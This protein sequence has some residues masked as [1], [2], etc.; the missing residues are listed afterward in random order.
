MLRRFIA[1]LVIGLVLLALFHTSF[2]ERN[3]AVVSLRDAVL[4]WQMAKLSGSV[5]F[6][7]FAFIDADEETQAAWG[8]N[9]VTPRAPVAQL[10]AF[11]LKGNPAVILID[12]DLTWPSPNG[13]AGDAQLANVL[14]AHRASCAQRCTPVLL[15]RAVAPAQRFAYAA[16]PSRMALTAIPSF[17]DKTLRT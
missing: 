8:F 3:R 6:D 12:L 17:L 15:V 13:A 11:A 4:S 14:G 9:P 16:S 2:V 10:I 5:P 7:S 1:N